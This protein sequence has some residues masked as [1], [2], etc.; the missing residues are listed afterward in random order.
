M[1]EA[2]VEQLRLATARGDGDKDISRLAEILWRQRR[3]Q[4]GGSVA[5]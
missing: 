2:L 3:N 1:T 4:I 5:T